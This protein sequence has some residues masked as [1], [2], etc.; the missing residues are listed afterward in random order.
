VIETKEDRLYNY[1]TIIVTLQLRRMSLYY[2]VNL[3]VPCC[4]LSVVAVVTFVLLPGNA[5]RIEIS[6]CNFIILWLLTYR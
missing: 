2:V 3:V 6:T 4:L 1:P 5:D